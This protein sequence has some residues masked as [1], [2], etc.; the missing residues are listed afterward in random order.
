MDQGNGTFKMLEE[1]K[2]GGA[3][4]SLEALLEMQKSMFRVGEEITIKDSRF[5]IQRITPKKLILKL[6]PKIER[7]EG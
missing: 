7:E 4:S 5:K 3:V 6:L 1:A 2:L